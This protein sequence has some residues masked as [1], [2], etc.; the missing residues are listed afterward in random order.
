MTYKYTGGGVQF[1]PGVPDRDLTDDEFSALT[2]GQ[3]DDCLASGLYVPEHP[4]KKVEAP[5]G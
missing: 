5:N 2:D 3:K 4:K 1:I